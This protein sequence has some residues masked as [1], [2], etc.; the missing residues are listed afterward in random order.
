M[1]LHPFFL[2]IHACSP[3]ACIRADTKAVHTLSSTSSFLEV[4]ILILG[5]HL[6]KISQSYLLIHED[7]E[8]DTVTKGTRQLAML[9]SPS[10]HLQSYEHE[11]DPT[12][13]QLYSLVLIHGRRLLAILV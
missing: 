10:A 4:P 1:Q 3:D 8:S 7:A 9:K 13:V 5:T 2:L 6:V 12:L 11:H